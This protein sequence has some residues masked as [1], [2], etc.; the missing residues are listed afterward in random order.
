MNTLAVIGE[1]IEVTPIPNADL[2]VQAIAMCGD[3][4]RWSGV[5]GK[6][7][8]VGDKMIVFLQ[9]AVLPPDVR[10]AFMEKHHWRVRMARFKGVPSECLMIAGAPDA[11]VGTD[12]TAMLGVSKYEKPIPASI[13]GEMVGAFPSFLSKTDEPN[14]QTVDFAALMASAPWYVTEKAD[15]SSCTAW[16]DETGLHVASRNW[17]LREVSAT[18]ASNVYWS[19]ARRYGLEHL[20]L[21]TAVQ[22]EVVGPGIQANPMG[23]AE[24]EGRLFAVFKRNE[25]HHWQRLP[26]THF[27][28]VMP[29]A[30]AIDAPPCPHTADQLRQLAAI[31]YPNGKHGEGVV[32]RAEDQSWSFKVI[33]L[34]YKD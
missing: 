5:V 10:W 3:A 34:A 6:H 12:V 29:F 23:L 20:A 2:I 28:A 32:V 30:R 1:I 19:T 26:R 9:D 7:T 21:G 11:P 4:G 17:E 8:Q 27:P 13:A 25:N 22:F 16:V 24:V 33:N 14:F 15:G 18:G 31:K